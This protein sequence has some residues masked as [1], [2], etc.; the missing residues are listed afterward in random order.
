M[1]LI[2][3]KFLSD[4]VLQKAYQPFGNL[5]LH[6]PGHGEATGYR[7]E[8]DLDQ[9]VAKVTYRAGGVSHRREVFA[10]HPD[11]V[12]VVR[13]DADRG[14]CIGFTLTMDSPHA[15]PSPAPSPTIPLFCFGKVQDDGLRFEPRS[16]LVHNGGQARVTDEGVAVEGADSA[17]LLLAAAT[18][19]KNFQDISAD[20]QNGASALARVK[21]RSYDSL[22]SDHVADHQ[23]LFR[24]VRLDLGRT[25]RADL[26]TDQRLKRMKTLATQRRQG[27]RRSARARTGA[28]G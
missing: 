1:P 17:T 8:L 19:Y 22:R 5:R 23:R 11:Q 20:P 9:A 13:F 2:R 7:R 10:S 14:G 18:S 27:R 24:R 15:W 6:F 21:A 25:D 4:P 3:Q 12:I 16:Q 26:P 28:E